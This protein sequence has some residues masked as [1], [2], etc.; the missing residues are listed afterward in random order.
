MAI[1]QPNWFKHLF[2]SP[3]QTIQEGIKI[4][5]EKGH[6]FLFVVDEQER[7]IGV[8]SDGDI[9]RAIFTNKSFDTKIKEMMTTSPVI[10]KIPVDHDLILSLMKSKNIRYIPIVD[11][12]GK[13]LDV[14]TWQEFLLKEAPKKIKRPEF[15]VIM[16]GGKGTRLDPFTK[17]L[18]KPLIPFGDKPMIEWIMD[19]FANFG[20]HSFWV[21]LNYKRQ[22]IRN[23]FAGISKPYSVGFVEEE[24]FLGTAGALSLLK[25]ELKNT[26]IVSNCDVVLEDQ[27]SAIVDFHHEKKYLL[28]VVA[29]PRHVKIPYGVLDTN[30]EVLCGIREKPEFTYLISGGIYVIEPEVLNLIENGKTVEMP[31]LI[32]KVIETAKDRVGIYPTSGKW[33]D[34]GQWEEYQ[35]AILKLTMGGVDI[36]DES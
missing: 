16:A 19:N 34:I 12:K 13:I 21:T 17:I 24:K 8:V 2:L 11:D 14:L 31:E 15:V 29:V 26:F 6:Q 27:L 5:N 22:T 3:E 33:F 7:L 25:D 4:L 36:D 18:P 1:R 10:A 32:Q 23:Y 28:T 9:R 30:Q 20:F 35:Q